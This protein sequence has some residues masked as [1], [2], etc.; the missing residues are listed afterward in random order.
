MKI[1]FAFT[2]KKFVIELYDY[3]EENGY[4]FG[5]IFFVY[6]PCDFDFLKI[7]IWKW[8]FHISLAGKGYM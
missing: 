3:R 1:G 6:S 8:V 4:A 2:I 7:Y 5:I